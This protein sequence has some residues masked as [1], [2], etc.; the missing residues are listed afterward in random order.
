MGLR[1]YKLLR[2]SD[3]D[4]ERFANEVAWDVHAR[5]QRDANRLGMGYGVPLNLDAKVGA[6]I[7][8][9]RVHQA[10]WG[11]AVWAT[12]GKGNLEDVTVM[13]RDLRADLQGVEAGAPVPEPD[14][15]TKAGLV[16]VAAAARL[17][18]LEGRA[19]EAVAVATLAS[20]DERSIRAV[21]GKE[22]PPV[23]PGR[24]MRFGAEVVCRYLYGRGVPG[25]GA[26]SGPAEA[27][28]VSTPP[29]RQ[30]ATLHP[31]ANPWEGVDVRDPLPAVEDAARWNLRQIYG[32][33][34][35]LRTLRPDDESVNHWV[36]AAVKE[37][38]ALAVRG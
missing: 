1:Q 25:F 24:P 7:G 6:V 17:A 11:C 14:L 30:G 5:A 20:L 28:A 8:R 19:L 32:Y 34:A 38:E 12:E 3:L 33:A 16:L 26:P 37:R 4:P 31:D 2:L 15:S 18:L 27:P 9:S 21:A 23:G 22:L 35:H 29:R 13:L 36:N 10:A